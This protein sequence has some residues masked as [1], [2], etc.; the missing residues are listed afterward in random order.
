MKHIKDNIIVQ[1][2]IAILFVVGVGFLTL[3]HDEIQ[4][5]FDLLFNH[6]SVYEQLGYM[7]FNLTFNF[8]TIFI[9]CLML[10]IVMKDF[11]LLS[12]IHYILRH[13]SYKKFINSIFVHFFKRISLYHCILILVSS[14][15]YGCFRIDHIV[16]MIKNTLILLLLVYVYIL[17]LNFIGDNQSLFIF[18]MIIFKMIDIMLGT[19][20]FAYGSI[21]QMTVYI[22]GYMVILILLKKVIGFLYRKG[23]MKYD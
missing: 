17:I 12:D 14:L 23:C 4:Y 15:I 13:H 2:I 11:V 19:H 6:W 20:F 1:F 5:G 16:F 7:R 3:S 9:Y 10:L 21:N 22:L 18:I 8:Y